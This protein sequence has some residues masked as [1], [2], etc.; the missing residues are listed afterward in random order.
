MHAISS[1]RGN[2]HTNKQTNPQTGPITVHCAAKLSAQCDKVFVLMSAAYHRVVSW[3]DRFLLAQPAVVSRRRRFNSGRCYPL[4]RKLVWLIR[5]FS[6]LLNI[7]TRNNSAQPEYHPLIRFVVDL[8][9]I[10]WQTL[11]FAV[12]LLYS[13]L[14]SKSTTNCIS[15]VWA[16]ENKRILT[17]IKCLIAVYDDVG[18]GFILY[19]TLITDVMQHDSFYSASGYGRAI[20]IGIFLSV[21]LSVRLSVLVLCQ[22]FI[23]SGRSVIVV[24]WA[25][26]VTQSSGA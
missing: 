14:Y 10:C 4:R 12:D 17:I 6:L 25:Q 15:G 16:L 8:L 11:R 3:C 2:T 1:Y 18:E 5:F 7:Y 24:F 23:S 26:R 20:L 21:C 22:T 9:W 13:L 19:W